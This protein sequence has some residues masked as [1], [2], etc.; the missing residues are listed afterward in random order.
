MI[1]N[2]ATEKGLAKLRDV[3][4]QNAT[5]PY[6]AECLREIEMSEVLFYTEAV[7][8]QAYAYETYHDRAGIQN[9]ITKSDVVQGYATMLPA[10][11]SYPG[12]NVLISTISSSIGSDLI[13]TSV[14]VDYLIGIH[15]TKRTM[16]EVRK[17]N[18]EHRTKGLT[19]SSRRFVKM[20]LQDEDS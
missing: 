5:M 13:F 10:L 19:V 4:R 18:K 11:E 20:E 9:N 3:L 1:E 15:H 17:V 2:I 12:E 16:E 7:L 6:A 14:E 8:P